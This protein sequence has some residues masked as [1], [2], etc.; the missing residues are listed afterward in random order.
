MKNL[1]LALVFCCC[2]AFSSAEDSVWDMTSTLEDVS[3]A[4]QLF[5]VMTPTEALITGNI[6]NDEVVVFEDYAEPNAWFLRY[7]SD[8]SPAVP[9]EAVGMKTEDE[10][11][12]FL[13]SSP[14]VG[15]TM[16][17]VGSSVESSAYFSSVTGECI[18][19]KDILSFRCTD[20]EPNEVTTHLSETGEFKGQIGTTG[21]YIYANTEGGGMKIAEYSCNAVNQSVVKVVDFQHLINHVEQGSAQKKKYKF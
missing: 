5:T 21:I 14:V 1:I 7:K 9:H 12:K 10:M 16:W 2:A 11:K 4:A 20:G 18:S 19:T 15:F 17:N 6:L 8:G 13:S 3:V